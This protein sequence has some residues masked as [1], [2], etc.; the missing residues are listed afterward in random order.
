MAAILLPLTLALI[1]II[2]ALQLLAN[3]SKDSSIT[4]L[5]AWSSRGAVVLTVRQ[6]LVVIT[7]H[8]SNR[9]VTTD[10]LQE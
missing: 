6:V 2:L 9:S 10:H 1:L 4:G 5:L 7:R 3:V 8:I